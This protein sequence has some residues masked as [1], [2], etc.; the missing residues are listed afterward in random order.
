MTSLS[1]ISTISAMNIDIDFEVYKA[2]TAELHDEHDTYN[3][4]IRRLL[5]LHPS[6]QPAAAGPQASWFGY[7]VTLPV[8]TQL[9]TSYKKTE[10][11]G[12][13]KADGLELD[14]EVYPSLSAAAI[15]IVGQNTNGWTFWKYH[16]AATR[17]WKPMMA[18][19]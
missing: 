18:L 6:A 2:L 14:G 9:R 7:D 12:T 15:S 19:R 3:N 5:G 17:S 16:D 10:R 13:V 11:I 1:P 8:G 4:V